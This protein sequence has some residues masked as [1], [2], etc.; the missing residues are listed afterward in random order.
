MFQGLYERGKRDSSSSS[1]GSD[2]SSSESDSSSSDNDNTTPVEGCSSLDDFIASDLAAFPADFNNLLNVTLVAQVAP[3]FLDLL[4]SAPTLFAD[5]SLAFDAASNQ[6]MIPPSFVDVANR[7]GLD[8]LADLLAEFLALANDSC[9]ITPSQDQI[10]SVVGL[11]QVVLPAFVILPQE[12]ELLNTDSLEQAIKLA[13]I[14]NSNRLS[15]VLGDEIGFFLVL[16]RRLNL[17]VDN[18]LNSTPDDQVPAAAQALRDEFLFYINDFC[19]IPSLSNTA[20]G[21]LDDYFLVDLVSL[22]T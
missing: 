9:G 20:L 2:D 14:L 7:A 18:I 1:G 10:N 6:I 17:G 3:V 4:T 12:C 16:I 21:Q 5:L 15:D 8:A 22:A 11:F 13:D 19:G